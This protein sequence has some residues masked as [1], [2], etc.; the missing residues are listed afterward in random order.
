MI[1]FIFFLQKKKR[2]QKKNLKWK[3]IEN[4]QIMLITIINRSNE[5]GINC[6]SVDNAGWI[7]LI[8]FAEK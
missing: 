5:I 4:K 8:P 3:L 7:N 1:H 2:K 6:G